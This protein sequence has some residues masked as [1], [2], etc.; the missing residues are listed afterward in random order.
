MKKYFIII[1]FLT[2]STLIAQDELFIKKADSSVL[3][4]VKLG[5]AVPD[6]PAF[7]ALGLDP[8]NILRP[9]EA[10]DIALMF[11]SFRSSG[12]FI[13]PKNLAVEV[14]P[15]LMVKPWFTL[16]QYQQKGALRALTKTR[17]SLG[18]SEEEETGFSNL[19]LGLHTTLIDK[20]DFRLDKDLL[21]E[22][23]YPLQDA[24]IAAVDRQHKKIIAQMGLEAFTA[25][26]Q[27]QKDSILE[28]SKALAENET[29]VSFDDTYNS[30]VEKFKKKQW[31]AA[32]MDFAYSVVFQSP[33][34]LL[35]NVKVNK[36]LFWL[37]YATRPGK[38]C[39]WAQMLFSINDGVYKYQDQSYNDFTANFRFY[40]GVNKAK[41]FIE[42]QYRNTDSPISPR[43]ETLYAQIGVEANFFRGIWVHFGTG[44]L[45]AL[46]GNAKS[47]ILS[48]LNLS[49]TLP[50][51][52]K[53]F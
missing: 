38:N 1:A 35:G 29:E 6:I 44:V 26:S 19:S 36:H 41:G 37:V 40:G 45:N 20:S 48:N 11:G 3:E 31:N 16:Q 12:N 21:K 32:R 18:T 49:L 7:K 25:L 14:T 22:K 43:L 33:D 5:F 9:S 8:S 27:P 28:V 2:P 52:L 15:A 4:N 17:L 24:Y 53:L 42:A 23:L 51:N 47:Q 10:K 34:S 39:N 13:I 50:D 46:N 30:E